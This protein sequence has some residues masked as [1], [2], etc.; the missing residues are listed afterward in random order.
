MI[1][2]PRRPL[3]SR[4]SLLIAGPILLALAACGDSSAPL[5]PAQVT[6]VG[7]DDQSV[8]VGQGA[9]SPLQ[10]RVVTQGGAPVPGEQVV[11]TVTQGSAELDPDT[12]GTDAN[13]VATTTVV[14]GQVAGA[15]VIRATTRQLSP[16]TF[17]LTA[18]PGNAVSVLV[19]SGGDQT[20]TVGEALPDPVVAEA[21]DEFSNPVP[22]VTILFE[23]QS[24][25]GSVA[26]AQVATDQQGRASTSWILGTTPGQQSLMVRLQT[27]GTPASEVQ[28]TAVAGAAEALVKVSGDEQQAPPADTLPNPLV[29]RAEDAFGNPVQGVTVSFT[30]PHGGSFT[31]PSPVTDAQGQAQTS[32]VLGDESQPVDQTATATAAGIGS[33]T[34]TAVA[35]DPCA[36]AVAYS[37]GET[38]NGEL[39][40]TDCLD[41]QTG[42]Y[43]DFFATDVTEQ[44]IAGFT[45][46]SSAFAPFL[47]FVPPGFGF[48]A[49]AAG[50][51]DTELIM[52]AGP[53]LVLAS[54]AQGGQTGAY[55]LSSVLQ[56]GMADGCNTTMSARA[57]VVQGELTS[58]D[59]DPPVAGLG[60]SDWIFT[61]FQ[62]GTPN[63]SLSAASHT[64]VLILAELTAEGCCTIV[65]ADTGTAGGAAATIQRSV[66]ASNI[67]VVIAT[68]LEGETTG[69]YSL[70]ITPPSAGAA[71]LGEKLDPTVASTRID[72]E[73][74]LPLMRA[75]PYNEAEA[76]LRKISPA[77]K[78]D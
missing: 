55:T 23:P 76:R 59:C 1:R 8:Q 25:A 42:R 7:G 72:W 24:G 43:F 20:G 13:G 4:W 48:L 67:F 60:Q 34:F 5:V 38:A 16:A 31:Q 70:S 3:A 9:P 18:E 73:T 22:G 26:D 50:A 58:Q 57:V 75:V 52:G 27:A 36:E 21:R 44:T 19:V 65:A 47:P 39:T 56:G 66:S 15:V 78:R 74:L 33:V 10:V 41:T 71:V 53:Y 11:W 51:L 17:S 29:V 69:P 49:N 54:S 63:I 12:S 45:L 35:R 2:K 61:L 37:I 77:E 6:I 32:W 68:T 46:S 64:P 14:M 30:T 40:T 28:A 62:V